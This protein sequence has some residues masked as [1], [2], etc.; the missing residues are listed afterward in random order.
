[1]ARAGK[2]CR[3]KGCPRAAGPRG[4]CPDHTL[5]R[6]ERGYGSAHEAAARALKRE[7]VQGAPCRRCGQPMFSFQGLQAA[8]TE[9]LREGNP[10]ALP[11]HL[12]H[13]WCNQ[14]DTR[15]PSL[16]GAH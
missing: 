6:H 12:E 11:D 15:H 13:P 9:A 1:M 14:G 5:S 2:V 10:D 8:H 7:H 4:T 3:E 16:N